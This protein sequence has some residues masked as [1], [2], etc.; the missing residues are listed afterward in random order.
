MLANAR[1]LTWLIV[2]TV[3]A[4]SVSVMLALPEPVARANAHYALKSP[5]ELHCRC[6]GTTSEECCGNL[7]TECACCDDTRNFN[8]VLPVQVLAFG[9][10]P[11]PKD[12]KPVPIRGEPAAGE[13]KVASE[14]KALGSELRRATLNHQRALKDAYIC[15]TMP[16]CVFCQSA[17][18]SCPCGN[19][20][21]KGEPVCPECW[22]GWQ[23]GQGAIPAVRLEDVKVFPKESLKT[24]Y[25]ARAKRFEHA[26]E[27]TSEKK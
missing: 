5:D 2:V 10:P 16:G 11:Q 26:L 23:A 4:V 1:R 7:G 3:P 22:G 15:C 14:A 25:E 9:Q 17:G 13:K 12:E 21:R 27:G 20:L 24:L 8:P 18:D 19:N 6:C